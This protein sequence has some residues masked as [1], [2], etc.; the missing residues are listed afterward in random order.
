M[1]SKSVYKILR[2]T[3]IA[4]G[5]TGFVCY[6]TGMERGFKENENRALK[7]GK[8]LNRTFASGKTGYVMRHRNWENGGKWER[9]RLYAEK[10]EE[11]TNE[12]EA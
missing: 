10:I 9:Y 7:L 8:I 1:S 11:T 2:T 6:K 3:V 12:E 5:I 4:I